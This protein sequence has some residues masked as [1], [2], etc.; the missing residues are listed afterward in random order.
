MATVS[1]AENLVITNKAHTGYRRAGR[2]FAMGENPVPA[3]TFNLTQLAALLADPRLAVVAAIAPVNVPT[4]DPDSPPPGPL[5]DDGLGP[6]VDPDESGSD[7]NT[8]DLTGVPDPLHDGLRRIAALEA[9][10]KL[11]LNSSGKPNADL[12]GVSA[13]ERDALWATWL[14]LQEG[15]A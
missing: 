5:D 7:R 9:E 8:L 10:G 12:I 2:A 15:Q 11:E 4:A 13:S 1:P 14:T 3:H 6:D